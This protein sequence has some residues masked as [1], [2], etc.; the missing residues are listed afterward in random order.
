MWF[1]VYFQNQK[2]AK[3]HDFWSIFDRPSKPTQKNQ[4]RFGGVPAT[5]EG[6]PRVLG[7]P[8]KGSKTVKSGLIRACLFFD[9]KYEVVYFMLKNTL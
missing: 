5:E 2:V 4:G 8:K 3:K 1:L 9:P 7:G 6:T